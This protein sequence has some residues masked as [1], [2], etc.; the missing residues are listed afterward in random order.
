M[1]V[2]IP[3]VIISEEKFREMHLKTFIFQ[4][5]EEILVHSDAFTPGEGC[6]LLCD[7]CF[8]KLSVTVTVTVTVTPGA[9]NFPCYLP[10]FR[11]ILRGTLI[12][13]HTHTHPVHTHT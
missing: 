5:L 6:K 2:T 3:E 11:D 12:S 4:T 10:F 13:V 7:S 1:A 8:N 9:S